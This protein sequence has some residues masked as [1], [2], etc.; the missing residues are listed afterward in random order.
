[1][2][3]PELVVLRRRVEQVDV[4]VALEIRFHAFDVH[5]VRDR[6]G[7]AAPEHRGVGY[8]DREVG[9]EVLPA[10]INR[11]PS[12]PGRDLHDDQQGEVR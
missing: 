12:A 10:R 5:V 11:P 4:V 1:M 6:A 3:R 8:A 9:V 2:A 7:H